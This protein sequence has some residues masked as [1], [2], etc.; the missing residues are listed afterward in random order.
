MNNRRLACLL[1]GLWIG[2]ALFMV[3][4][5]TQNF[6]ISER[7][8]SNPPAPAAKMLQS[9]GAAPARQ[10]LRWQASEMN[11]FYFD[12][13]QIA[14]LGFG[15]SLFLILLFGTHVGRPTLGLALGMV[16]LVAIQHFVLSPSIEG[17]GRMLDFIPRDADTMERRQFWSYHRAY[18][19]LEVVKLLLAL[20]LS[21]TLLA[22]RG[23]VRSRHRSNGVGEDLDEVNHSNHGHINR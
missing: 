7:I 14:Q 10:L 19:T 1:L 3:T 4:V 2:G 8:V 6:Q 21:G 18:S 16:I 11:R 13:W 17:L 23:V 9:L 20:G 12:V 15:I 22:S 5:A